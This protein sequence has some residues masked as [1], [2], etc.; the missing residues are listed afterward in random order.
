MAT[1]AAM[2]PSLKY[3]SENKSRSQISSKFQV[4]K[5]FYSPRT[6]LFNSMSDEKD[7]PSAFVLTAP[8]ARISKHLFDTRN[9]FQ[10]SI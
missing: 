9:N 4:P 1:T 7:E 2:T 8:N 3:G 10:D 5:Y 6:N